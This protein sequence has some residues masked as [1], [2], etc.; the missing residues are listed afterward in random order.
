MSKPEMRRLKKYFHKH[1][2]QNYLSKF[3][4]VGRTF[5]FVL[6]LLKF[7][8]AIFDYQTLVD[9]ELNAESGFP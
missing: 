9:S 1:F 2:P 5:N 4:K 7:L 8:G 3:K 6:E